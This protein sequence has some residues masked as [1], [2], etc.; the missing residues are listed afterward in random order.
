M[1]MRR[2]ARVRHAAA[3]LAVA[4]ALAAGCASRG[5]DELLT[6][7]AGTSAT[8]TTSPGTTTGP[9]TTVPGGDPRTA[10]DRRADEAAAKAMVP[11][12][13]DFPAGWHPVPAD[14][15]SATAGPD[16]KALET[17]LAT[18]LH[19]DPAVF[20]SGDDPGADSPTFT[21][22][23]EAEVQVSAGMVATVDKAK[24]E[25]AI[26]SQAGAADCFAKAFTNA[27]TRAAQ[28]G[29]PTPGVTFGQVTATPVPLSGLG[30]EAVHYRITLPVS[31]R[32]QTITVTADL[33]IAR[34]GRALVL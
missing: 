20:V 29:G 22:A 3:G 21:D 2:A 33:V 31:G 11:T 16:D 12:Q 19:V 23:N 27:I 26:F 25:F 5:N 28:S 34:R 9:A 30:D 13:A 32:G 17:D 14:D 10:A 7:G 15:T 8:T 1:Q 18:C 24:S 4:A 6:E